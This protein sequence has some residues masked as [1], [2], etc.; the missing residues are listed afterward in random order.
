MVW[1]W[2]SNVIICSAIISCFR[3][4][5]EERSFV[6]APAPPGG[7][8]KLSPIDGGQ[9]GDP[10]HKDRD[11]VRVKTGDRTKTRPGLSAAAPTNIWSFTMRPERERGGY[12][13]RPLLVNLRISR[14]KLIKYPIVYSDPPRNIILIYQPAY[15]YTLQCLSSCH[16][17]GVRSRWF[18][19]LACVLWRG[20]N[21]LPEDTTQESGN[22]QFA[23]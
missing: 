15:R 3:I 11:G 10:R 1:W 18:C 8:C 21:M 2:T 4:P 5:G 17:Q 9:T 22:L 19:L 6:P 7:D 16:P 12:T 14:K 23:N 20:G 13:A